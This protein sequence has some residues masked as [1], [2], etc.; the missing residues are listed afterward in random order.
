VS[1]NHVPTKIIA[2]RIPLTIQDK[3]PVLRIVCEV[4]GK[5]LYGDFE[6]NYTA[7]EAHRYCTNAAGDTLTV[8]MVIEHWPPA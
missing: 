3:L 8:R 1:D 6:Y 7:E 2:R 4:C 5:G